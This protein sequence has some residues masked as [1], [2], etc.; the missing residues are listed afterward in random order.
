MWPILGPRGLLPY[1]KAQTQ[2]K[3]MPESSIIWWDMPLR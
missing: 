3:N 2:W 1:L